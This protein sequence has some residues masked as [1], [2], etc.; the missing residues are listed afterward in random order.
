M[1]S[2]E[3]NDPLVRA[4]VHPES[5]VDEVLPD[6][7]EISHGHIY[8]SHAFA[9]AHLRLGIPGKIKPVLCVHVIRCAP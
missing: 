5:V 4:T 8:G 9:E 7:V 3:L 1:F 2:L 6:D